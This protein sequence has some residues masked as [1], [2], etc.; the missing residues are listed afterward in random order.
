MAN[1]PR[2]PDPERGESRDAGQAKPTVIV[3]RGEPLAPSETFVA[4]QAASLRRWR[5]IIVGERP[6]V[7]SLPLGE[8]LLLDEARSWGRVRRA[9]LWRFGWS[10]ALYRLLRRPDVKLV[11]AHFVTD[12][13]AVRASARLARCPLIVTAHGYDVS[14][15]VREWTAADKRRWRALVRQARAFIA[16]SD[17]VAEILLQLGVPRH[18]VVTHYTGIPVP[19]D[20]GDVAT[21]SG[22][23]FVGRLVDKKGCMDLLEAVD[24]LPGD[25]R[26]TSVRILG[27]GA[28]RSRLE[29]FASAK[30]LNVTFL[31][32]QPPSVVA[33]EMARA[34]LLCVPSQVTAE[35][36]VEA[37]GMVF[38]EASSLRLPV[39]TYRSA[40]TPES[41]ADQ[42][43]GLLVQER[44]VSGLCAALER[45][46]TDAL[47]RKR[48]GDQGR[49]R[50]LNEFDIT[51]LGEA[52]EGIYDKVAR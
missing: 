19:A 10:G 8:H 23:L 30:D 49:A 17:F 9:L 44:D 45:L 39:L 46:L 29:E 1:E 52:L 28:W 24:G 22:V 51:S 3:W 27:D 15:A 12:A 36:D 37:F 50:V 25:L 7:P 42:E 16:V 2:V 4:N 14:S 38:L 31:G 43:S 13:F 18:K 47:L 35:G 21:R 11:H 34:A 32:T 5:P 33:E 48:L 40:G 41:V 26:R 6:A 20:P